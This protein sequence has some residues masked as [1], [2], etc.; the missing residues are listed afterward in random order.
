MTRVC[1]VIRVYFTF[2]V[3]LLH[4]R[5]YTTYE[6]TICTK[7]WNRFLCITYITNV[8]HILQSSLYATSENVFNNIEQRKTQNKRNKKKKKLLPALGYVKQRWKKKLIIFWD[9]FIHI[10]NEHDDDDKK[11]RFILYCQNY[12]EKM[13]RFRCCDSTFFRSVIPYLNRTSVTLQSI[14]LTLIEFSVLLY[15]DFRY[16]GDIDGIGIIKKFISTE[17][18]KSFS[19]AKSFPILKFFNCNWIVWM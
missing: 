16:A 19:Y 11:N 13:N 3:L 6:P 2:Y 9:S 5:W 1:I 12:V 15:F 14:Q 17:N 7:H 10:T 18:H 8:R 4:F